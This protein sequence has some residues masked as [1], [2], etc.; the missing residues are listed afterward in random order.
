MKRRNSHQSL[1]FQTASLNDLIREWKPED[2]LKY[3]YNKSPYFA[4]GERHHLFQHALHPV[5]G[6]LIE[7]VTQ[8]NLLPSV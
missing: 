5:V 6:M 1:Q 4:P 2:L 3:A 8:V 7:K